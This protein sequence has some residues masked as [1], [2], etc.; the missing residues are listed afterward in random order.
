M[1]VAWLLAG[2][3]LSTAALPPP[4]PPTPR[5][6]HFGVAE[7]LPSSRTYSTVQ[8]HQ[9]FIWVGTGDGLA[10]FDGQHFRLFRHD[11]DQPESL[12]NNDV[13]ALLVDRGGR[14]WV[15]GEDG[16][17]NLLN[18]QATGF[19]HWRHEPEDDASLAGNDIMG[20]AQTPDGGIWIGI[21]AGGIDRMADDGSH[22]VHLRHHEDDPASL[23]SDNVTALHADSN[24][25]LWIGSD[26]GLD[27]REP[28][29]SVRHVP[30]TGVSAPPWV[31]QINGS[32]ADIRVATSA[33]LFRVG[34][35]DVARRWPEDSTTG[36]VYSSLREANG[37]LWVGARG[38]LRLYSAG[39]RHYEFS[40][41]PLL[42]G[43]LPGQLPLE[44]MRDR[45]GGLWLASADAGLVYLSPDWRNFSRFGHVPEDEGSLAASRVM[46]LTTDN[47]GVLLVGGLSGQLDRLDPTSG[48]VTH[49][50]AP[51]DVSQLP[52][53]SLATDG[54][55]RI[56]VGMQDGLHVFD[57]G[58]V[59]HIE[60]P[61]L[62]AG[63]RQLLV[64]PDHDVLVS[65]VGQGMLRVDA[66]TLEALA[67][68]LATDS[69][70]E[71]HTRQL[72]LIGDV[73]WRAS[74][75]G[76]SRM[77]VAVHRFVS[78]PGVPAGRIN[79]FALKG[80]ALWLARPD[81]LERYRLHDGEAVRQQVITSRDGFPAIDINRMFLDRDERVW[82]TSR[83]G[84][85]RYDPG[86]GSFRRYG[87][88]DGLPSPEFTDTLVHLADGTVYAGTFAGVVGF[89]PALL[90][91]AARPPSLIVESVSV[92]RHGQRVDLPF[93]TGPIRLQWDDHDL[94]VV[95]QA[96]S[97][98]NPERNHYRFRM[99]GFDSSWVDTGH[100]GAREFTG[101]GA[102]SFSLDVQAAGPAGTWA[103]L[104]QALQV[105]VDA[106]P[107]N[108]PWAWLLYALAAVLL[109]ILLSRAAHAR[110]SRRVQLGLLDEQ[111]RLAEE[112]SAAKTR[113]LATMG[114]E[115][116]T[117]MTGVLGMAELLTHTRLDQ[118]QSDM[119]ATIRHSGEVLLKLVNDAL[120]LARIEAGRF[121]LDTRPLNPAA[122]LQDVA[123][124]ESGVAA[125]KGLGIVVEV[126]T[127]VPVQV[128]GDPIRL[129]QILLN[130]VSNA[131]KFSEQGTVRLAL[132][133]HE[134]SLRYS[135]SDDGPGLSE[136]L[137]QRLFHR[138]EQG[139]S[140]SNSG[141]SGL[142]LA[143]CRE[144]SHLM[145][146]S[147]DVR[148]EPG[149]G[150][151]F[152]LTLPLP[153]SAAELAEATVHAAV[154]DVGQS[155]LLVEDDPIIARVIAG[156]LRE[157]GHQVNHVSNALAALAEIDVGSY[158][159]LLIDID[160][161]GL[162]GFELIGML[163]AR[164]QGSCYNIVVVTARSNRD[165]E[166]RAREVGADSFMRKP[167]S[168]QQLKAVFA[169]L[170]PR[171]S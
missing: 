136:E 75:A 106:P 65:P 147:V 28:D 4:M 162:D 125:A 86:Q 69:V 13:S 30:F 52:V 24:G 12:P 138:F 21:Y 143:I 121:E 142:G 160:L 57:G 122:A 135:V 17:L 79:G 83:V 16:G 123:A 146:G 87:V 27:M 144:L 151:T 29:G 51:G 67:V 107:W 14:L 156:L 108:R 26:Q 126:A 103:G 116:R 81:V 148:S 34:A 95:S 117:P 33:G 140:G 111:R 169:K 167:V 72:S 105:N 6:R 48:V 50:H 82:M 129:R 61:L 119:V 40:T 55:K 78:V 1:L 91:D 118:Q 102:G 128:L 104:P 88:E 76:L 164:P 31:W 93:Q 44:I 152:M 101:L 45:E 64:L 94:R 113:F 98:I 2:S 114:H 23:A 43:G 166:E 53:L 54:A 25:R 99:G 92:R 90:H 132:D 18:A 49:L 84:L 60:S 165:D 124:L 19:T 110:M 127:G 85:W 139:D 131:L 63:I 42:P 96:L 141:G 73:V 115:I 168:G 155:V 37:D 38:A 134:G 41:Q 80:D 77:E 89:R 154:P 97:F 32:G 171:G 15:G 137:R 109:A 158:A 120:D 10:R 58:H 68:P 62:Q 133:I 3:L 35:D 5:F 7:G 149:Q 56:W 20:L 161:P 9:G 153:E 74:S 100:Q 39:G 59:R 145:G 46:S 47:D 163:R 36:T 130:L 71:A 159:I 157:Q 112:A 8:D 22:F 170:E 70:A 150:C 66:K 11:P